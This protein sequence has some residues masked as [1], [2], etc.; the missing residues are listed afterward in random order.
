M[1]HGYSYDLRFMTWDAINKPFS[2]FSLVRSHDF[3]QLSYGH[4]SKQN[5]DHWAKAVLEPYPSSAIQRT[6]P[7]LHWP[8]DCICSNHDI[9]VALDKEGIS[10]RY[11]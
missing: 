5:K 1:L 11:W 9:L 3:G 10:L 6:I 8:E 2:Y 4:I 7:G